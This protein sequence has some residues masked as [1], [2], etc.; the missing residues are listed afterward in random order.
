MKL[1]LSLMVVLSLFALGSVATF[2][3]AAD[4]GIS[5]KDK[6]FVMEAA[7]G[8]LM[9][10]KGGE[11]A[12][13][14][15]QSQEVKDFGARMVT[16]HGK[17]NEELKSLAQQKNITLPEKMARHHKSMIDKVS[18]LSGA[19]FDKAYMRMMVKDHTKD[20]AAFKKAAQEAKDPDLKAWAGKT[21]PILEQH[22]EQAKGIASKLGVDVEKVEKEGQKG[23]EKKQKHM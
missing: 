18:K 20:V 2:A 16:D 5:G 9:E 11:L 7:S 13:K 10:V 12:Q 15:G 3:F 21:Q 23:A 14:K 4:K 1:R 6:K 8:G 22:L 19:D 17:A